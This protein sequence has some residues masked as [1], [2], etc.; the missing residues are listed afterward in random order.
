[1]PGRAGLHLT[2]RIREPAF[3]PKLESAALQHLPGAL[4]L[5]PYT[6][7][8]PK[9]QGLCIGYGCIDVE[10]IARAIREMGRMLRRRSA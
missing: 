4:T 8:K 9:W 7:G 5:A 2:A 6:I 1:L 10:E 3:A